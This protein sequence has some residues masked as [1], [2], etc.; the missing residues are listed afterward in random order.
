M[1]WIYV[2]PH[3]DDAVLS[4]GGLIWEQ[5]NAGFDVSVW[6][7]CAGDPPPGELS[8][9]AASLHERWGVGEDAIE[10]RR[11]EDIISCTRVG[12]NYYHFDVPDCIYRLSPKTG[13]YLYASEKALW[14]AIHPEE[15]QLIN[16]LG[17]RL[18]EKL[19]VN[20]NLVCPLGIGSHVDHKLTVA[21]IRSAL[22]KMGEG[23]KPQVYYYAEYPY[24]LDNAAKIDEKFFDSNLFP[25][26][27]QGIRAWQEAVISHG[28]QISTFW[29]NVDEMKTAIQSFHDQFEGIWLGE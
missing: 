26:S 12:A 27:P 6:T 1:D 18:Q 5:T 17:R 8:S 29:S 19:P 16:K 9:F 11:N 3:L 22:E 20:S 21:V 28:S 24:V 14:T 4:L 7:V 23:V 15:S 10:K 13:E 25:I 2:S